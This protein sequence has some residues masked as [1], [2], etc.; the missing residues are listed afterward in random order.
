M[1]R[2][3]PLIKS[4]MML[5]CDEG[6]DYESINYPYRQSA[7]CN[8][9][10]DQPM[11]DYAYLHARFVDGLCH[12]DEISVDSCCCFPCP[13]RFLP[14]RRFSSIRHAFPLMTR[15]QFYRSLHEQRIVPYSFAKMTITFLSFVL[16]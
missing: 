11:I 3:P 15:F 9:Y 8:V 1:H 12:C 5:G 2:S 14:Y 13:C 4:T 10:F 16:L 7:R 6:N